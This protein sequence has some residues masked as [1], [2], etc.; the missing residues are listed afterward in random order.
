VGRK[1]KIVLLVL[2]A[3]VVGSFGVMAVVFSRSL[4]PEETNHKFITSNP[5][6]LSQISGFSKYRSCAGHDY[7]GPVATTGKIEDTPRSM[8]HYVK[9]R[10]DL[11]GKNGIVK[12]MAPFDGKIFKVDNDFGGPGDQQIWLTP[13]SIS[14]RQWHFVFFHIALEKGLKQGSPIKAGQLIGTA[15]LKRGPEGATD[16]FDIAVKFT[17]PL[18][19]P[20]IDA[21]FAHMTQSVLDGYARHGI[22]SDNVLI[23]EEKRN[24]ISCPIIP[25]PSWGDGDDAYFSPQ[26]SM[27]DMI[28]LK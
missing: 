26:W 13:N 28:W 16:N 17:R 2:V 19:R 3:V 20:A 27:D 24:T 6:D 1:I 9:V 14:P 12:A 22:T 8:K 4:T 11:Q 5:L 23:S 15:N 18:R 25:K 10:S 7:R 21:P